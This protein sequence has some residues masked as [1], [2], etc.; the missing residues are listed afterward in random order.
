MADTSNA[1]GLVELAAITGA[2]GVN[3][4]VRLKLFGE[5]V[6]A[7]SPKSFKRTSPYTPC[8]PVMAASS[9]TPGAFDVSAIGLD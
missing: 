1:P 6:E 3:G 2:H 7:L 4:E 5:G 8:A 9:T